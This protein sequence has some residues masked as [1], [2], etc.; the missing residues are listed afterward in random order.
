MERMP[1]GADPAAS[2]QAGHQDCLECRL[3]GTGALGALS[4]YFA[5]LTSSLPKSAGV[6]HRRFNIT[7]SCGFAVASVLRFFA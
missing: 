1:T 7:C 2:D 5:V 3:I 6:T 4:V